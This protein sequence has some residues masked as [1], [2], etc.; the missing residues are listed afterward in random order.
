MRGVVAVPV[1]VI[2]VD[3][4]HKR[5]SIRPLELTTNHPYHIVT[6]TT[7]TI[8]GRT[9]RWCQSTAVRTCRR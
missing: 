5:P 9:P 8:Q 6:I 3:E 4:T 2:V 7:A 1:V